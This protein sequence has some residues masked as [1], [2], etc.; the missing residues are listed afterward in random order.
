M[1][2]PCERRDGLVV[3]VLE[4]E[5]DGR[6]DLVLSVDHA[7]IEPAGRQLVDLQSR[8]EIDAGP[9]QAEAATANSSV[10]QQSARSMPSF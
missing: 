1:M 5:G 4:L 3:D 8:L 7:L 10:R 9:P 2:L 6:H